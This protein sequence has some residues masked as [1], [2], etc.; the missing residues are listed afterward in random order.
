MVRH[1][2]QLAHVLALAVGIIDGKVTGLVGF[3]L[4]SIN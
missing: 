3:V 4:R 2:V 1:I